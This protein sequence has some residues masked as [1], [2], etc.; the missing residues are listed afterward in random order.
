MGKKG[1]IDLSTFVVDRRKHK[2]SIKCVYSLS[3]VSIN[4]RFDWLRPSVFM[5]EHVDPG[6][7]KN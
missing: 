7:Y 6:S 5:S 4:I 2:D 3:V 1:I